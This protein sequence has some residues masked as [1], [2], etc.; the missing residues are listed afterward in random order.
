VIR[1]RILAALAAVLIAVPMLHY[2]R[3]WTWPFALIV[4]LALGAFAFL[5]VRAIHNLSA[6][7]PRR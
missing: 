6:W 1:Q 3:G 7:R 4:G 2:A 5:L